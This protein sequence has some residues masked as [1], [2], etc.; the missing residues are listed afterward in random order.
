MLLLTSRK[1]KVAIHE[2][3]MAIQRRQM[4]LQRPQDAIQT[5]QVANQRPQV[6]FLAFK[7]SLVAEVFR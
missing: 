6:T 2:Y 7:K 4:A 5:L 1:P 3:Q